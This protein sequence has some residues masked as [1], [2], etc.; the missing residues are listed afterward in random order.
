MNKL[1][2][3]SRRL[4]KQI[5]VLVGDDQLRQLN[6]I[7]AREDLSISQLVRRAISQT[8]AES[9]NSAASPRAA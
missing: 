9:D 4:N 3:P 8:L 1:R 2:N 5:G 7:A 6:E